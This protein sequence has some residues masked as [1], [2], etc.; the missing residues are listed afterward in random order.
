VG[1]TSLAEADLVLGFEAEHVRHA[2]VDADA[3]PDRSFTLGELVALLEEIPGTGAGEIVGRARELVAQSAARRE[4]GDVRTNLDISDPFRKSR[5]VYHETAEQIRELSLKL[6]A[7][8][9]GIRD[10]QA[11]PPLPSELPRRRFSP[12]RTVGA[13]RRRR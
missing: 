2:V 13:V 1:T 4:L 9:F 6:V 11:L 10:E 5:R 8:L 12:R 7:G 3:A